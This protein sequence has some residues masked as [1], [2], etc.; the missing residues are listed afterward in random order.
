MITVRPVINFRMI[1]MGGGL[2]VVPQDA[3]KT[4]NPPGIPMIAPVASPVGPSRQPDTP[5]VDHAPSFDH[6]AVSEDEGVKIGRLSHMNPLAAIAI[7]T[8]TLYLWKE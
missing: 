6:D 2:V 1:D 7:L 8:L 5:V 4:G 3:T